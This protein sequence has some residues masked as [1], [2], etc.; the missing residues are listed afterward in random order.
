[1]N[2]FASENPRKVPNEDV[3]KAGVARARLETI[4]FAH[5]VLTTAQFSIRQQMVIDTQGMREEIKPAYTLTL[6]A[7]MNV[8]VASVCYGQQDQ[9][10]GRLE[11]GRGIPDGIVELKLNVSFPSP[12]W[13]LLQPSRVGGE[14]NPPEACWSSASPSASLS[15]TVSSLDRPATLP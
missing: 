8:S 10:P 3:E 6:M 14:R 4:P 2:P 12:S 13:C 9:E 7:A 11:L 1:M 5:D 15:A